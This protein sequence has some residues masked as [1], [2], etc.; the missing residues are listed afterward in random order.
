M[1]RT[2]PDLVDMFSIGKSY[3]GRPLYV[4]QVG[5]KPRGAL[6]E[7]PASRT[8]LLWKLTVLVS[9]QLGKRN[10]PQKKAVWID[11]GVH[12][13]EWIGPAFCQ[14][15]VKEV[16]LFCCSTNLKI[17]PL[18]EVVSMH[19]CM[20]SLCLSV[21]PKCSLNDGLQRAACDVWSTQP[22]TKHEHLFSCHA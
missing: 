6:K 11:C 17:K 15:F 10:R 8:E 3:E 5:A 20:L 19:H 21:S 9:R 18:F 13:R 2:H 12:A 7:K 1:N 14:W 16:V 22:S 4:L